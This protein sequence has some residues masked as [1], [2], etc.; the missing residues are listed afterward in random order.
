MLNTPD[1]DPTSYAD[2]LAQR[3]TDSPPPR[4][5]GLLRLLFPRFVPTLY[6]PRFAA[7]IYAARLG[8]LLILA[9]FVLG[10]VGLF[11]LGFLIAGLRYP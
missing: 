8:C 2:Y 1:T 10:A 9:G 6:P 7:R 3:D 11:A 5:S 4:R